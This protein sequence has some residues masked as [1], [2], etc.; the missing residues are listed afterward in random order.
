MDERTLGFMEQYAGSIFIPH[1]DF[2]LIPIKELTCDQLYQRSL[3]EKQ[4]RKTSDNFDPFQI[5]PVKVS[6]R[7]GKNYVI[8]GQ[9][10]MEI[11]AKV[12]GSRDTPVWCM[13]YDELIYQKEANVFADQTRFTRQLS[14]YEIFN[15]R[16][17]S[18]DEVSLMIKILAENYGFIIGKVK[19]PGVIT[20]VKSLEFIYNKYG[21][22][23]LS[24]TLRICAKTWNGDERSLSQGIL[25]GLAKLLA[26]YDD[27]INDVVFIEKLGVVSPT[28][29]TRKAVDRCK[30]PEGFA[31]AMLLFY[32]GKGRSS[33]QIQDLIDFKPKK[34]KQEERDWVLEQ[35]LKKLKKQREEADAIDEIMGGTIDE[36]SYY[37]V[38]DENEDI[39]DE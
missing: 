22:E 15:A 32:N 7:D 17:E 2:E 16:V 8:D 25:K 11:V 29:L 37:R 23:V 12:S 31:E 20:N 27:R 30:G 13:I 34:V 33:L 4:V 28:Q 36:G 19:K 38:L 9:H 21:M 3:S 24:R 39:E 10:T 18:G 6:K 35:G 14:S 5:N 26:A 1:V